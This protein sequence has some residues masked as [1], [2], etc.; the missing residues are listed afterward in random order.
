MN[1]SNKKN[2]D[3][4]ILLPSMRDLLSPLFRHKLLVVATFCGVFLFSVLI[5]WRWAS[6]YYIAK[7][8]VIVEQNRSDPAITSVQNSSVASSKSVSTDQISSEVA[9]LKGSDMYRAIVV[10]CGLVPD[11]RWSPSDMFISPS[12]ERKRAMNLEKA[13][14]AVG[15]G[16][17]VEAEKT[18]N[19]INVKYGRTGDPVAPACVLQNLS[20]LYLEKHLLLRRPAGSSTF[21]AEQAEKYHQDLERVEAQ[22]SSFSHD[23][24]VAAPDILRTNM[25]QQYVNSVASLYQAQQ[26]ISESEHRLKDV[27]RQ[28]AVTPVRSNTQQITNPANGLL[29][30]LQA[31]LLLSQNKRNQLLTKYES[32]YPLVQEVDKEIAGTQAAIQKAEETKYVAQTTD[33]DT[34]YEYLR[35]DLAK[36]Q[37]DLASQKAAAA[38]ISESIAKMNGQMAGFDEK[39][40]KQAALLREAKADEANYLLYASKREQERTSDAL[41]KKGIA[42][43]AIA[44]PAVVP[45]VPAYGPFMVI[46]VGFIFASFASV[47]SAFAAEY[48]DSSF[49]TPRDVTNALDI[50]VLASVPRQAA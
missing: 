1:V 3:E 46:A 2:L 25:A 31:S 27:T 9:L 45:V 17:K 48:F 41:D 49:R 47:F 32:T 12:P 14:M 15:G 36:T 37:A 44:V 6:H 13:A 5:A 22:L 50:P 35:Q 7:M 21:F 30:E 26:S 4:A 19:V 16:V 33:R 38:A 40:I 10:T 8:Q 42:D 23:Q 43:V 34:T 29:Q 18:S 39:S 28:M 24:G 11:T 20:K